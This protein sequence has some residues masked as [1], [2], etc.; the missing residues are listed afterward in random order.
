MHCS[1]CGR[2]LATGHKFCAGCGRPIAILPV[3]KKKTHPLVVFLVVVLFVGVLGE[4]IDAV[5]RSVDTDPSSRAAEA[6]NG[7]RTARAAKGA[8]ML[9]SA[10]R[11]S[12]SFQLASA[13]FMSTG[14]VCYTYRAQNGFGGLDVGHA[15]LTSTGLIKTGESDG[16]PTLWNQKCAK[17]MGQETVNAVK[18]ILEPSLLY[19]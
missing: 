8:V 9:R 16:F 1:N 11:N 5:T 6:E 19:K 15:V 14:T 4:I 18:V 3:K 17:K 2:L 10:M 7:E 13:L 12:D